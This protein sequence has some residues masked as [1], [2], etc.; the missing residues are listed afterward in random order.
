MKEVK[1][2]S[3]KFTKILIED[4]LGYGGNYTNYYISRADINETTPIGEFGHIQFQNG[5]VKEFGINGC[6]H[7][8]LLAIV[9]DRLERFQSGEWRCRENALA[10]TKLEEA[11]HWLNHRTSKRISTDIE[12][13]SYK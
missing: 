4:I 13:T 9:I 10:L 6:Y 12:G 5:P 3:Q 8:D 1:I 7:E 2:G 11:M